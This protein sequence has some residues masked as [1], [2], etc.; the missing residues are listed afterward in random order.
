[1][2]PAFRSKVAWLAVVFLVDIFSVNQLVAQAHPV[3]TVQG[4]DTH[5]VPTYLPLVSCLCF[6][7]HMQNMYLPMRLMQYEN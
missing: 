5:L 1:M 3:T 7:L 6:T 4:R 2:A